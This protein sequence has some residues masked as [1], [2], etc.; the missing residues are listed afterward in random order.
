MKACKRL[1]IVIEKPLAKKVAA[2]LIEAGAPGFTQIDQASGM[3]DRGRRHADDPT[4]SSTNCVFIIACETEHE[5][6]KL[7]ESI[8]PILTRTGGI[9]LVSDAFWVRH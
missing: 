4:G 1:E 8:R 2:A 7:V 5:V 3:G 9:C 6:E